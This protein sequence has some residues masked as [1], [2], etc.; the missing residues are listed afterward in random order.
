MHII[1]FFL[2][3]VCCSGL[4]VVPASAQAGLA[5]DDSGFVENKRI[6]EALHPGPLVITTSNPGGI[7]GK[8]E[9]MI[10]QGPGIH[11]A[12]ETHLSEYTQQPFAQTARSMAS[13]T[14]R[15]VSSLFGFPAPLRSRSS[16]AGSWSGVCTVSDFR[17]QDVDLQWPQDIW[18]SGRVQASL[19]Y[20]GHHQVLL[21]NIYGFCRGPTW[22]KAHQLTQGILEHVTRH[23]VTGYSGFAAI[24]GDFNCEPFGLPEMSVWSAY[25]WTHAQALADSRWNVMQEPTCQGATQPDQMWLS[26]RLASLRSSV[27]VE[28]VFLS[29]RTLRCEFDIEEAPQA[30]WTWPRPSPIPWE[31]V[32]VDE[33]HA[34]EKTTMFQSGHDSTEFYSHFS[35]SFEA[36]L[37]GFV[38]GDEKGALSKSQKGRG[39]RTTPTMQLATP[40]TSRPSRHGEIELNST[41]TGRAVHAWFKQARRL[42]SYCH[43]AKAGKQTSSAVV[44]R[45]DVWRSIVKASGFSPSFEGWWNSH[46]HLVT[47]GSFPKFPPGHAVADTFFRAF[48]ICFRQFEAWHIRQRSSLNK[49][50]H[51]QQSKEIFRDLRSPMREQID[52]FWQDVHFTPLALDLESR[53]VHLDGCVVACDSSSWTLDG[54]PITV[55]Q[56]SEDLVALDTTNVTLDSVLVQ[57]C[58]VLKVPDVHDKL[59][60]FWQGRWYTDTPPTQ[61][62]WNR[63][64][65]FVQ[66]FM[67][68]LRFPLKPIT[69]SQWKCAVRRFKP[70]AACGV[71]GFR[72][73]DLV[74]MSDLKIESLLSLLHSIE[75][76]STEWPRQLLE[77]LVI[78]LAKISSP[79]MPQHFR[80]IILL[81]MIY[82][83]WSSIRGRQMLRSLSHVI[84]DDTY[85]SVPGREPMMIW[86]ALQAQIEHCL[87]TG[88]ALCGVSTDIVKAFNCIQRQPLFALCDHL[89]FSQRLLAPWERFLTHFTRR[90]NVKNELSKP[91]SS[92]IGFPEGCS[93]SVLA[94]CTLDWCMHVY[95]C[96]FVVGVRSMSYVDN[97]TLCGALPGAVAAGLVTLRTF[98]QMWGLT[99][100]DDKTYTWST[101][102]A[103]RQA[104]R[105]LGFKTL[106]DASE[107]GGT[108]SYSAAHRNRSFLARAEGMDRKWQRLRLSRSPL[109]VKLLSLPSVFWSKIL[110][111]AGTCL[112]SPQ[113]LTKL[114]TQ[115]M[116]ALSLRTAGAN[117]LLRLSTSL[118]PTADPGFFLLCHGV[119][120]FRRMCSKIPSL[121]DLW[122]RFML[123]FDGRTLS[124]PFTCL[125][126]LLSGIGWSVNSPPWC[127]DH[128]GFEHNLLE[129][130]YGALYE[131]L[132]DGWIQYVAASIQHRKS[133]QNLRGLDLRLVQLDWDAM[134]P[135]DIARVRAIQEGAFI[136]SWDKSRFDS[137]KQALCRCCQVP[138]T[139]LHWLSCPRY[140]DLR[141]E[142]P[143]LASWEHTLPRHMTETL[144]ASRSKWIVQ[145]KEMLLSIPVHVEYECAPTDDY[146]CLFVDGSCINVGTT[147]KSLAAWAVTNATTGKQIA[148]SALAGLTQTIGRAELYAIVVAVQWCLAYRVTAGIW[149]DSKHVVDRI[150]RF[151]QDGQRCDS[152]SPNHDLWHCLFD[153][154][155]LM[156][157]GQISLYWIPSH[158]DEVQCDTEYSEWVACWNNAVDHQAVLANRCRS[159]EVMRLLADI[160]QEHGQQ[161]HFLRTLREFFL[162]VATHQAQADDPPNPVIEVDD[163]DWEVLMPRGTFSDHLSVTWKTQLSVHTGVECCLFQ[164]EVVRTMDTIES[165]EAEACVLSYIE[166]TLIFLA[167]TAM[168]FPKYEGSKVVQLQSYSA[169]Y[170]RPTLTKVVG[171]VRGAFRDI[172]GVSELELFEVSG[173][174]RSIAGITYPVPGLVC[175]VGQQ[176]RCQLSQL[177]EKFTGGRCVRRSSD[178]AR[179]F[180]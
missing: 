88:N 63:I 175:R 76:E 162:K 141:Q 75:M 3:V 83:T 28:D 136:A 26:P 64:M 87:Q 55:S 95:L 130:D 86:F 24:S 178:L 72:K 90:F 37:D 112:F 108:M 134:C 101:S 73:N 110:H 14:S 160:E 168:K 131:L 117:P 17:C 126:S 159:P 157:E 115:A 135:A 48:M 148:A 144:L 1:M 107:L 124:G 35:Q 39:Q 137:T 18:E 40:P 13:Q 23:V 133:F 10:A 153:A 15:R 20:I 34:N 16:W 111:G 100:D 132:L 143:E 68:K 22:P 105:P 29:H 5:C 114:R 142:H 122:T 27:S 93:L 46:P 165:S 102:V 106:L 50:K 158:L 98:F 82:R 79:E 57:R 99:L 32:A 61:E 140:V 97:I 66:A 120:D 80:P 146:Q 43:S 9:A 174:D 4:Q 127:I 47:L 104:L 81:S 70:N 121:V 128:D 89:G 92:N 179:P 172:L 12:S 74:H 152:S 170:T 21:V 150:L 69:V 166:L 65:A 30:F 139:Q 96:R 60:Q 169:F 180:S 33:W 173:V 85:G 54:S 31:E 138:D 91:Y 147:G 19:H 62:E 6:G 25:G 129:I 123:G 56:Q 8:E 151:Q 44:Y 59:G 156:D 36:S 42:Q 118:P 164:E 77:G 154:L 177:I 167:C 119:M 109:H 53:L 84:H 94:M 125:V 52:F 2:H 7:R 67:P 51:E 41:L 116:T 78:G 149:S 155:D 145:W 176:Y 161:A 49:L 45:A 11:Q 171:W 103:G 71:D 38:G 113:H 163:A 58:H